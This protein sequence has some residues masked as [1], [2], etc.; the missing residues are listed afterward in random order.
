MRSPDR[1]V[2]KLTQ[3]ASSLGEPSLRIAAVSK[4]NWRQISKL[5]GLSAWAFGAARR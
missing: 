1:L 5:L 2:R 3:K 4:P